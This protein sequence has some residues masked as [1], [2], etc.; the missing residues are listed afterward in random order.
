MTIDDRVR[1][2][3]NLFSYGFLVSHEHR[4]RDSD[5]IHCLESTPWTEDGHRMVYAGRAAY[6]AAERAERERLEKCPRCGGDGMSHRLHPEDPDCPTCHGT[7][8]TP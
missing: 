2:Y 3:M 4:G 6:L 5:A 7:G 1:V 8:R